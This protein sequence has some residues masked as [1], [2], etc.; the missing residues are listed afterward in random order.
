MYGVGITKQVVHIAK[1]L[2]V[3]SY[4][5][6]AEIIRLVL[7]QAVDRQ[8]MRCMTLCHKVCNLAIR[9][10]SD[11]LQCSVASRALVQSLYRHDREQLVDSPRVWQTLE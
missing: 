10:A 6:Y 7:F 4:E 11:I 1:N 5:E 8:H 3:C 9:V 2:L